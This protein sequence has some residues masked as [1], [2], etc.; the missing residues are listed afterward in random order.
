MIGALI[1]MLIIMGG[2]W[3]ASELVP[4]FRID[5]VRTL[6]FAA[7]LLGI[8]NAIVR[9]LVVF[10]T[11]PITL[12]TLGLF[13]FVINAAML[14]LVARLLAGFTIGGFVSALLG[15]LVVSATSWLGSGFIGSKGRFE[16]LVV[17]R[18]R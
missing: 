15:S 14:G 6:T 12:V 16:V 11:F 9:P 7:I 3:L 5:D 13:L 8:V 10:L 18:D 1:R 17:R 4:G 2:L